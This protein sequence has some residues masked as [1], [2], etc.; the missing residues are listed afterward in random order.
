MRYFKETDVFGRYL[1]IK[2]DNNNVVKFYHRSKYPEWIESA[3]TPKEFLKKLG[4]RI[5]KGG[6][7]LIVEEITEEEA[8]LDLL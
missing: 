2:I 1:L 6:R 4:R 8:F 7:A 3:E 5:L